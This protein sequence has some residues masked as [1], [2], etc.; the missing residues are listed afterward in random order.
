MVPK[1]SGKSAIS[2]SSQCSK[3]VLVACPQCIGPILYHPDYVGKIND[4]FHSDKQDR[5][6]RSSS[7]FLAKSDKPG[8]N[9]PNYR[10]VG[11]APWRVVVVRMLWLTMQTDQVLLVLLFPSYYGVFIF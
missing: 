4:M 7:H 10:S 2:C 9:L 1:L 11:F 3:S 5:W 8:D 6:D